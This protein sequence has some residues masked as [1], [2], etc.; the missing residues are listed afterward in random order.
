MH[1]RRCGCQRVFTALPKLVSPLLQI[2]LDSVEVKDIL[3]FSSFELR[4]RNIN[5]SAS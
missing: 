1:L 5:T 4:F 3:T 2:G